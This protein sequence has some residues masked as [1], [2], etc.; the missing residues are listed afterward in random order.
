METRTARGFPHRPQPRAFL[1]R[2]NKK[3][4]E[5]KNL[6]AST[7]QISAV[8]GKRRHVNSGL[9]VCRFL[10]RD[11]V[12]VLGHP[13]YY[14][15][16]GFVPAETKGLRCQFDVPPEAFMVLELRIGALEQ[17]RG[18]VRYCPEFALVQSIQ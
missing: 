5:G 3:K 6:V 7:V 15:K 12:V 9:D 17:T 8:S 1:G 11:A 14:P 13:Q 18:V 4:I 16:F 2:R 10:R